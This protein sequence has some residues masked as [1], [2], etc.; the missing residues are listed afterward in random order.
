MQRSGVFAQGLVHELVLIVGLDH[1]A[2][3]APQ[4]AQD[5]NDVDAVLHIELL[6]AIA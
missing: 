2:S 6:D 4:V 3:I 1:S 5:A